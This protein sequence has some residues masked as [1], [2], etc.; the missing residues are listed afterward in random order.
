MAAGTDGTWLAV[1]LGIL[2]TAVVASTA[3]PLAGLF[4]ASADALGRATTYLRISAFGIPAMLVLTLT[5]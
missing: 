4:G 1:G 5:A 3:R 2:T